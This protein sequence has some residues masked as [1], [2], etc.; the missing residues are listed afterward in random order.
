ML[1]SAAA[2]DY[3]VTKEN[4]TQREIKITKKALDASCIIILLLYTLIVSKELV[5]YLLKSQMS[6]Y[7]RLF[8]LQPPKMK[9]KQQLQ[10]VK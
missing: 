4:M 1:I 5:R 8:Q 6:F 7:H 2:I 10:Q 9:Q 3:F